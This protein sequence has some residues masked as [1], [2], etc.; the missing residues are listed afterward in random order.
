SKL[1]M[2]IDSLPTPIDEVER[3]LI[4]LQM[5]EQALVREKDKASKARLEEVKREI[6]E[7][8]TQRDAMRAQWMREKE[9]L[10]EIRKLQQQVEELQIEEERLKRVGDLGP[11]AEIHYGKI[12]E[13]EKKLASLRGTLAQVQQKQS[14][15]KEEVTDE[16]VAAV[17]SKWTGIPISKM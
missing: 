6:A 17:I 11:A 7:L 1:R 13:L 5:E 2:E 8:Q 12:P 3:S 9:L 14:Y 16:D 4:K 10:G 15:L